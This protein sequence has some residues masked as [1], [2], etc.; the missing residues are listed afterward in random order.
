MGS[1][2][3]QACAP[4]CIVPNVPRSR[5]LVVALLLLFGS[6]GVRA[7]SEPRPAYPSE[8]D[9]VVRFITNY[10]FERDIDRQYALSDFKRIDDFHMLGSSDRASFYYFP[11]A[12][13][14]LRGYVSLAALVTGDVVAVDDEKAWNRVIA[15]MNF[16]VGGAGSGG[17]AR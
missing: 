9:G 12:A 8:Q 6:A 1:L 2:M 5:W 11:T 7:A 10:R 4:L 14:S 15:E 13:G 17:G 16:E 3:P